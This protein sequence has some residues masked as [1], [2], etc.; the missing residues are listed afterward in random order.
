MVTEL[1]RI[2]IFFADTGAERGDQGL[3]FAVAQH[4]VKARLFRVEDFSFERQ[5]RLVLAIAAL[6]R[7]AARRVA[8]DDINLRLLRIPFLTIRELAR[9]HRPAERAFTHD[10]AGF[11]GRFTSPCSID[12]LADDLASNGRVLLEILGQSLI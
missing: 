11:S 9:Q 8:L 12:R 7:G 10:F 1:A 5:N 4:P 3:D 6:L 2:E